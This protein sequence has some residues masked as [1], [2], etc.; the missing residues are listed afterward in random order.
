MTRFTGQCFV[1]AVA[2]LV[3]RLALAEEAD[4]GVGLSDAQLETLGRNWTSAIN[5]RD[6]PALSRI[7]DLHALGS[8]SAATLKTSEAERNDF[9]R[10]FMRGGERL[11]ENWLAQIDAV[12]GSAVFLKVHSF[13]GM[14]GPLVRYDLGDQGYNYLL[15]IAES[16]EAADP[17]VADIF[18][19][20]T[21]QRFSETLGA[22]SLMLVAP[23]DSLLGELFGMTSIDKNLVATFTSIGQLQRA[24][25]TA[26]AYDKVR[27]LPEP[28]RNHRVMMNISV[29]LA[30]LL[31]EQ[32]YREELGR[33]ARYHRDDPTAAFTLIDY[34]FYKGDTDAAMN[35]ILGMERAFGNDGAISILKANISVEAGDLFG[36]RRFAREGVEL[37]PDNELGQ[38]T[39][40]S[41]LMLSEQYTD[42]IKVLE[43]LEQD[44]GYVFDASSFAGEELYEGFVRSAEYDAWIAKR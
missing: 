32:L 19:A 7:L 21:G 11:A 43:G 41:I 34:Y 44:F 39:L 2:L 3:C 31:S 28:I 35:A 20:T 17:R 42:G 8:R 24:G 40:L 30:S 13:D 18:L 38:L 10:G 33:L 27:G 5:D 37:E 4:M 29:Q 14:R 12:D 15:L 22:I 9:V 25:R 1:V 26:E 36:A 23:N 16:R 6:V